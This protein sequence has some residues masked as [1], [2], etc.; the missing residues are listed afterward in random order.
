MSLTIAWENDEPLGVT[1]FWSSLVGLVV[2]I[3]GVDV[4]V[5]SINDRIFSAT[6]VNSEGDPLPDSRY[7][8]DVAEIESIVVY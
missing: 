4:C 7:D 6:L 2:E 8:I 3:N 1:E 5:D